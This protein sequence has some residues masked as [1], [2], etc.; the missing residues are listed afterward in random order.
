M[1]TKPDHNAPWQSKGRTA[2]FEWLMQEY[3]EKGD[4][5]LCFTPPTDRGSLITR[6]EAWG[7]NTQRQYVPTLADGGDWRVVQAGGNPDTMTRIQREWLFN[8]WG[9]V[10]SKWVAAGCP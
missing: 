10:A 2:Y 8:F 6:C 3:A 9:D 4:R 7:L 5:H 1:P